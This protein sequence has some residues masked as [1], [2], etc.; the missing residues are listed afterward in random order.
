MEKIPGG[1]SNIG[2]V[3]IIFGFSKNLKMTPPQCKY[4]PKV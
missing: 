3:H 4:P 1:S 2:A